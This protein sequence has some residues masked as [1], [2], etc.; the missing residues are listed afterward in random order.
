MRAP[1]RV[2]VQLA[3]NHPPNAIRI[4]STILTNH[5]ACTLVHLDANLSQRDT[6]RQQTL[7]EYWARLGAQL[8]CSGPN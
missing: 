2:T 7:G 6:H 1:A 8:R 3:V 5:A 4:Y